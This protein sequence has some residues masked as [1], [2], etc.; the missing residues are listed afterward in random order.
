MRAFFSSPATQHY[1]SHCCSVL[2][3]SREAHWVMSGVS[4]TDPMV[5]AGAAIARS[6]VVGTGKCL[7][8]LQEEERTR[9]YVRVLTRS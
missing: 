4:G 7:R 5:G 2:P 1:M 6:R 8:R 3:G 9:T